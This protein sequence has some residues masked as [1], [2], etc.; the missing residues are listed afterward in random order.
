MERAATTGNALAWVLQGTIDERSVP[1]EL[2]AASDVLG[3][4]GCVEDVR[5]GGWYVG[6]HGLVEPEILSEHA[7]GRMSHPVIQ[8]ESRSTTGEI[9]ELGETQAGVTQVKR[10]PYPTL[11]KS[12]SSKTKRYSFWSSSPCTVCATPLGKYQIS[13]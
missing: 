7:L 10:K 6:E 2:V 9:L 4:D 1:A 3:A 5:V 13:P 8:V 12:A 11:S